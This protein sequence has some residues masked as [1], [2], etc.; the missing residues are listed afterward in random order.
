MFSCWALMCGSPAAVGVACASSC[1]LP[2][3]APLLRGG[4]GIHFRRGCAVSCQGFP[5]F[6]GLV[7]RHHFMKNLVRCMRRFSVLW[8]PR[9]LI[10]LSLW[11]LLLIPAF[12]LFCSGGSP[13][14]VAGVCGFCCSLYKS[15]PLL[16]PEP[17]WFSRASPGLVPPDMIKYT[18]FTGICPLA[19]C[20]YLREY[21]C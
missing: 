18:L 10:Q 8:L 1:G 5:C 16:C 11:V 7:D 20:T 12:G 14:A 21:V 19:R 4:L 9:L 6:C 17:Y 2:Y 13:A 3:P 15:C